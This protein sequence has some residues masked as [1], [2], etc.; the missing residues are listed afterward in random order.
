MKGDDAPP[1]DVAHYIPP[2]WAEETDPSPKAAREKPWL[3]GL[4]ASATICVT[5]CVTTI[6][7]LAKHTKEGAHMESGTWHHRNILE[8]SRLVVSVLIGLKI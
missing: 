4:V 8:Y 7:I 1:P 6:A 5:I 3:C 2:A